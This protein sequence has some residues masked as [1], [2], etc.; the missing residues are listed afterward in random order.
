ANALRALRADPSV[1]AERLS[2]ADA[3]RLNQEHAALAPLMEQ[4][5]SLADR[6]PAMP[7]HAAGTELRRLC[8]SLSGTLLP[9][10][11]HDDAQL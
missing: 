4:I 3:E 6:L 8:A 9:H 10:E 11:Q 7:R 2:T 1:P 5:R